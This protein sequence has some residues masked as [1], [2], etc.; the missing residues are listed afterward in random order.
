MHTVA[1][2]T[3]SEWLATISGLVDARCFSTMRTVSFKK[4]TPEVVDVFAV[5]GNE[6]PSEPGT[7]FNYHQLRGVPT[8]S[9]PESVFPERQPHFVAELLPNA[10]SEESYEVSLKWAKKLE[11]AL[12]KTDPQNILPT[13]YISF[14]DPAT[15]NMREVFNDRYDTLAELKKTYDPN[16][17]FKSALPKF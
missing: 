4:L 1:K 10:R 14:A 13:R 16:N 9:Y 7:M 11:E 5:H 3:F 12:Q 2:T 6:M 8:E 15:L 17:V